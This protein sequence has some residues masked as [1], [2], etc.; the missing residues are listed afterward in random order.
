MVWYPVAP[1]G[2]LGAP[3]ESWTLPDPSV[4]RTLSR[5]APSEGGVHTVLQRTHVSGDRGGSKGT[6][7]Q[8][9]SLSVYS[10]LVMRRVPAKATPPSSIA[11]I[12][13]MSPSRGSSKREVVLTT[14][15]CSQPWVSQ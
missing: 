13:M 8:V 4:A 6:S 15:L 12:R 10:T 3:P 2:K 7:F 14:G 5:Y 1:L 11:P 9:E